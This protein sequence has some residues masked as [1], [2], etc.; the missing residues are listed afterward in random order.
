MDGAAHCARVEQRRWMSRA[1]M[2]PAQ[3]TS[4][5]IDAALQ[6]GQSLHRQSMLLGNELLRQLGKSVHLL[7]GL[8]WPMIELTEQSGAAALAA[9][10][11]VD[12][13]GQASWEIA[14]LPWS[15]N[16]AA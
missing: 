14:R 3:L 8:P 5:G 9:L 16:P 1:D 12:E 6:I 4:L 13:L 11:A 7:P 2:D 15:R 10:R